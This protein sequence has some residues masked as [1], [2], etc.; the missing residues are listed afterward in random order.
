LCSCRYHEVL[1]LFVISKCPPL[2]LHLHI[3]TPFYLQSIVNPYL[4]IANFTLT[5]PHPCICTLAYWM[6]G[7]YYCSWVYR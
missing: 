7:K 1:P 5:N 2:P 3:Y 6:T 4:Y